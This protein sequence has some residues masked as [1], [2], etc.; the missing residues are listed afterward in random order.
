[1]T[2]V[3]GLVMQCH[4]WNITSNTMFSDEVLW[5]RIAPVVQAPRTSLSETRSRFVLGNSQAKWE[6]P[7]GVSYDTYIHGYMSSPTLGFL[8]SPINDHSIQWDQSM[9]YTSVYIYIQIRYTTDTV[10]M[11]CLQAIC[12][13]A[14]ENL[15][16]SWA[17]CPA[18]EMDPSTA[19]ASRW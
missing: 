17:A 1:M 12:W 19:T 15:Y 9:Y 6:V 7:R 10:L 14:W 11:K 3:S 18:P 2:G 16:T 5:H 8:L 13:P 4:N